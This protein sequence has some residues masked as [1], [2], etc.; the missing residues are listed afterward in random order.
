MYL[1]F[2]LGIAQNSHALTWVYANDNLKVENL[3][4]TSEGLEFKVKTRRRAITAPNSSCVN[5]FIVPRNH[6]DYEMLAA[7]FTNG[8]SSQEEDRYS[9]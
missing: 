8:F 5:E 1:F 2:F 6:M 3:A 4:A 9:F 7:F